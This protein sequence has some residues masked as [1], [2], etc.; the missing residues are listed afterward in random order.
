MFKLN[1]RIRSFELIF[2]FFKEFYIDEDFNVK[3]FGIYSVGNI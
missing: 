1:I 3:V 2:I